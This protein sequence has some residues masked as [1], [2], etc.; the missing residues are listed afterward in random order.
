VLFIDEAYQLDPARGGQFAREAM[1]ELVKCL[2]HED[3]VGK[4]VV[5]LAGYTKEMEAMLTSNSGLQSRFSCR[6]P[7]ADLDKAAVT[8][9]L[10]GELK[11]QKVCVPEKLVM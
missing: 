8:K 10:L 1:D 5:I 4:M 7:F 6:L 11:A 3:F 2:T 9:L